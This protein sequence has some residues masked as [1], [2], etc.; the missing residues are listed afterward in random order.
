[1][2]HPIYT[3]LTE[4][5]DCY[6]CVRAC[7][8][9][10][11]QV[12]D[13]NAVVIHE[14]CIYCGACVDECPSNAKKVRSDLSR[15]R[16]FMNSASSMYCSI[17]PSFSAEFEGRGDELLVALKKL[18]FSY[19]SETAIGAALVSACIDSYSA[20]HGGKC[21]WISTACPSVVD[22]VNKYYPSL[23]KDLAPVPSPLQLHCAYLRELYGEKIGI[24]FIGPCIAKK[25]EADAHPGYP[26]YAL[27]FDELRRW[28]EEEKIDLDEIAEEIDDGKVEIPKFIPAKAA[29]TTAYS[30]EG[31]MINSLAC[32]NDPYQDEAVA[33]SGNTQI[34][35][36]L[37]NLLVKPIDS[38]LELLSCDGGCINGPGT[39]KDNSISRKKRASVEYTSSRLKQ[40]DLFKVPEYFI[41]KVLEEGYDILKVSVNADR[42][43]V[44]N[45]YTEEQIQEALI[46]LGKYD[47]SD[48]LNCGG[49]GYNTCKDMARAY[50]DG[51]AEPE[52]CVTKMRKEAQTKIDVL[53]RTIPMGVV[54]VDRKLNIVDCNSIFISLFGDMDVEIDEDILSLI[55]GLPVERFV[56]FS[57]KFKEQ[58]SR[59]KSQQYRF[60]HNGK[61]LR[62]SFFSIENH[63][64]VGAIFED[65]TS[66]TV[67]RETVVKKAEVVIQHS[68]E[69]VQQI[70]SLLGENA[71]DTEIT[72]NS[73]IEAFQVPSS[74][75]DDGFTIDNEEDLL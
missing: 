5:R 8:V 57:D 19:I 69:T 51:M 9:K 14:R 53:L 60:R 50:L 4:C 71:A 24:V 15:V 64:L 56:S 25:G 21:P 32:G 39:K 13:G 62:V 49:C 74:S 46:N 3:E 22:H 61:F 48:Q 66:P 27:T 37:D 28:L 43:F 7:P 35:S 55:G 54:M 18:G 67:R 68:L 70:A 44:R 2:I 26:N 65:I 6:K 72:L 52:M 75:E 16:M 1:M 58:F 38:F 47:E 41:A 31:G 42:C 45:E 29:R 11:I 20:Q 40:D 10:A 23:S 34:I 63:Q 73:L 33:A 59:K 36:A 17:A 12:K 30:I